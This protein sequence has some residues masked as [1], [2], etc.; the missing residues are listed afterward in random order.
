[1]ELKALDL[2]GKEKGVQR[3]LAEKR[4]Q[5]AQSGMPSAKRDAILAGLASSLLG[6]AAGTSAGL[7]VNQAFKGK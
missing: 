7:G 2:R 3:W 1:M 6:G 4:L 5:M